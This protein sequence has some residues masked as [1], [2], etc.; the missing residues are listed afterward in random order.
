MRI[1]EYAYKCPIANTRIGS[2]SRATRNKYAASKYCNEGY[3]ECVNEGFLRKHCYQQREWLSGY[4]FIYL[5][6]GV[7]EW[8]P[9]YSLIILLH[10]APNS[11]IS[12]SASYNFSYFNILVIWSTGKTNRLP[13]VTV[14]D[15]PALHSAL[16]PWWYPQLIVRWIV[17]SS[18][19]SIV[20][21][22]YFRSLNIFGFTRS[23]TVS[24][25]ST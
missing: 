13:L 15:C 3:L 6:A 23:P 14:V 19:L 25:N 22:I 21:L 1:V 20:I 12:P 7:A 17:P 2:C 8:Q 5:S 24:L 10:H 4:L 16:L 18:L 11:D 9:Y